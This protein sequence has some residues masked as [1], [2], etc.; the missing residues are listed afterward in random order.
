M[1]KILLLLVFV[2]GILFGCW[3]HY[4][5]SNPNK[6][7][8]VSS[9]NMPKSPLAAMFE[10]DDPEIS[11]F[12]K[13]LSDPSHL[14]YLPALTTQIYDDTIRF[15]VYHNQLKHIIASELYGFSDKQK[16][17]I[18]HYEF[19]EGSI[20]VKLHI[21]KD[22]TTGELKEIMYSLGNNIIYIDKDGD[23]IWDTI[24]GIH[25]KPDEIKKSQ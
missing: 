14:Y 1:K 13:Q 25:A 21:T 16:V 6:V 17:I 23:G 15:S 7:L 12:V 22:A 8:V 2:V 18:R 4:L 11:D 24:K 19:K 20:H 3:I 9:K 10:G 5:M